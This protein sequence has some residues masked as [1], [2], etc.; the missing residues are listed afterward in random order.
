M[1]SDHGIGI[2]DQGFKH[3]VRV[4]HSSVRCTGTDNKMESRSTFS[5]K[6]ALDDCLGP[7]QGFREALPQ[8]KQARPTSFT[9][10][11]EIIGGPGAKRCRGAGWPE[12]MKLKQPLEI[13][14][15]PLFMR[16]RGRTRQRRWPK[17]RRTRGR[18]M[19]CSAEHRRR[20]AVRIWIWLLA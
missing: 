19:R 8:P 17:R 5:R 6:R 11:N 14:S 15:R 2:F 4:R 9:D 7:S 18:L 16:L 12:S 3:I 1:A 13:H 10:S 20:A